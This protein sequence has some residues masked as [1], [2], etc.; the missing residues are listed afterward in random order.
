MWD[1]S[2]FPGQPLLLL[3]RVFWQCPKEKDHGIVFS[4]FFFFLLVEV[5]GDSDNIFFS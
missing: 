2:G 4:F 1:P 5:R 3:L